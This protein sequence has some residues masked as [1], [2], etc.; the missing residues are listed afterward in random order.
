MSKVKYV[1]SPYWH[2]DPEV[3]ENN[4]RL[5]SQYVAELC[6]QGYVALSVITYG[7]TILKFADMPND[8][9]FWSDFCLSLLA[10]ADEL[11]VYKMPGWDVSRGVAG[12]IA[13]AQEHNIPIRYREYEPETVN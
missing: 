12:E 4:Y 7:H 5:V 8:W 11:I 10:K 3:I 2:E 9:E 1:A 13:F 6:R